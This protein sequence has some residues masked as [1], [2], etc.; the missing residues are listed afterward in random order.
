MAHSFGSVPPP[1]GRIQFQPRSN[2]I[3]AS[4]FDQAAANREACR[5]ALAV[6]ANRAVGGGQRIK[7]CLN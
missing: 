4:A 2:H 3:L 7:K 1:S 6:P 5:Q